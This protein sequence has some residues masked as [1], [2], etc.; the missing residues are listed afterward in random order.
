MA[1]FDSGVSGYIKTKAVVTVNFPVDFKGC[2]SICC[3]QCQ[4]Y[5]RNSGICQLTKS[6]PAYPQKYVGQDCPL[7]EV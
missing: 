2:A 1:N 3:M 4:F 7:K 6:I 5:S